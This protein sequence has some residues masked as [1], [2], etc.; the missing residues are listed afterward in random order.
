MDEFKEYSIN[1][2]MSPQY[3]ENEEEPYM[4]VVFLHSMQG[5]THTGYSG[6]AKTPSLAWETALI[7]YDINIK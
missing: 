4:W 5:I 3:E 2:S 6:W 7:S 1:V